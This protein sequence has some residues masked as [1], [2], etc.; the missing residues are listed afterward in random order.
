MIIDYNPKTAPGDG[1][2]GYFRWGPNRFSGVDYKYVGYSLHGGG[3]PNTYAAMW[4]SN[5]AINW[6]K[7]E[8]LNVASDQAIEGQ[9]SRIIWLEIDP[10]SIT[11]INDDE[12]LAIT[13][14]HTLSKTGLPTSTDIYEIFLSAKGNTLTRPS[15]KIVS[16]DHGI[17]G[18][19]ATSYRCRRR[20]LASDIPF[21][22]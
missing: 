17:D 13:T 1:H 18:G 9:A 5:N 6:I 19:M 11:R 21:K 12:Y 16:S 10:A 4:G 14:I 20:Y 15:R 7:I 2:T 8:V 22:G 3:A